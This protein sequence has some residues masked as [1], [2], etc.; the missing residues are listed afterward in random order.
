[1]QAVFTDAS[2]L[3]LH[4]V[5]SSA[6]YYGAGLLLTQPLRYPRSNVHKD[7]E[8]VPRYMFFDLCKNCPVLHAC[9]DLHFDLCE[10]YSAHH[11][12]AVLMP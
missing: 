10:N 11:I 12:I 5:S 3:E 2:H 4:N 6:Q 9:M 7:R 8:S 1:M